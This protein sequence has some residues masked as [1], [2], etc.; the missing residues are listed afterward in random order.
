MPFEILRNDLTNMQVDAIVN[1]ANPRPMIGY[2]VDRSVHQKAGDQLLI[3]RKKIGDIAFGDA[4]VTPAFNLKAKYV[5]H[6]VSPIWQDGKQNESLLLENC[7]SKSLQ[8]ALEHH[9]KS[10][11][12]PLLS[13]GNHGFPKDLALQIAISAFSKF[14]MKHEIQIYLV[15]FSRNA[16]ALSE[17]LFHSVKSYIDDT[18]IEEKSLEEY[19]VSNKCDVQDIELHQLRESLNPRRYAELEYNTRIWEAMIQK[20]PPETDKALSLLSAS[21][22]LEDL[23]KEIDETFSEGL[24]RLI[25]QKGL[26]DPDVYKKANIDRKLFSKI[27]NNKDYKP[28]K[29]TCIAFAIAL[30]LN[31]DETRDLIGKAG[32]ALTHSSKFDIIIE[33]FILRKNY[34]FFEINEVLFAFDQPLIGA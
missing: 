29:A 1:A 8:L 16:L 9:C 31:L 21:P 28:A 22:K 33:Y 23:M 25:D 5:I 30:E 12:F 2:G 10:I 27:K 18:Y 34:N 7:Y 24:I 11:A 3:A 20:E 6:T 13:A 19:G 26:K 32:Y 15:V 14:L 4:A 17:K